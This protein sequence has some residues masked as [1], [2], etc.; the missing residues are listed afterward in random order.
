MLKA[1]SKNMMVPGDESGRGLIGHWIIKTNSTSR[2]HI[3]SAG[4]EQS[5]VDPY[6][7]SK[8]TLGMVFAIGAR[9]V[10]IPRNEP[11]HSLG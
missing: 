11:A 1:E 10:K 7:R 3:V 5:P 2:K 4:L 6:G 9:G 8:F